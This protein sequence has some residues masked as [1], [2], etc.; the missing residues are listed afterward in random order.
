MR[1][2]LT[3]IARDGN[4]NIVPS[5]TITPFLAGTATAVSIYTTLAGATAVNS[6][7]AGD[8]GSFTF[9]VDRFDYDRDQCFDIQ[10][11]KT[12][13]TTWTWTNV[14]I[15][16]VVLGTYT[17]SDNKTVS[18]DL[19][20]VP[21]GV[22]YSIASGKTLT[23]SGSLTHSGTFSGAGNLAVTGKITVHGGTFT[24]TGTT[25]FGASSLND[26]DV[27][28]FGFSTSAA[29]ANNTTYFHRAVAS[30]SAGHHLITPPGTHNIDNNTVFNPPD[31]CSWTA[32]GIL[33]HDGNAYGLIIGDSTGTT[34][35]MYYT[36]RGLD[37]TS[38][39]QD[40]TAPRVAIFIRNLY[41]SHIEIKA[42]HNHQVGVRLK[43]DGAGVSYN[44]IYLNSFWDNKYHL[45]IDCA[46]SG[47]V[48][49]NNFYGGQ[50]ACSSGQ[51]TSGYWGIY[52][53]Y[54]ATHAPNHNIFYSPSFE[55]S[56]STGGAPYLIGFYNGGTN[57]SLVFPRFEYDASDT[58]WNITSDADLT[59]IIYGYGNLAT[60]LGT[61]NGKRTTIFSGNDVLFGG[62]GTGGVIKARNTGS[63]AYPGVEVQNTSGTMTSCIT[64]GGFIYKTQPAPSAYTVADT[65]TIAHLLTRIITGTHAVG[66]TQ[67]YTLP[68]GTNMDGGVTLSANM[69]FD[70]NLINLSAAAVDTITL[71]ANTGHTI[72]GN[73]IVQSAHSTTGG[74]YGNSATFRSRRTAA[75]TWITYRV[76]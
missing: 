73:P 58:L 25:T 50:F 27:S 62:S 24:H 21:K 29:A 34:A 5:S 14:D 72:V 6:V 35:S 44:N 67:A 60:S 12:G 8:D 41:Y 1:C 74:I 33:N 68:T 11:S 54:N 40:I 17:I 13:W 51:N 39:A 57:C 19:G 31:R 52:I 32:Y 71:T 53:E 48:N 45:Y 61:D 7:T 64:A 42:A 43:G 49:Y 26:I 28:W 47:W 63:N 76:A 16:D 69:C 55:S 65:L 37:V 23:L 20:L 18:T 38:T 59:T 9:Y 22:T 75:N 36:I 4:G 30:M 15:R 66:S 2:I 70:W 10:I 46:N 3:G 56:A